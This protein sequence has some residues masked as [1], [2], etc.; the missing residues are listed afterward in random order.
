MKHL[1]L[2]LLILFLMSLTHQETH[3]IDLDLPLT[4]R[5]SSLA[6]AKRESIFQFI[7]YLKKQVNKY[8]LAFAFAHSAQVLMPWWVRHRVGKDFYD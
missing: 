1:A 4:D 6:K 2:A 7:S 3:Q 8:K 5:Y